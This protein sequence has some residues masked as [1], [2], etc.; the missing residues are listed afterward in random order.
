MKQIIYTMLAVGFLSIGC[1]QQE[2][3]SGKIEATVNQKANRMVDS[4]KTICDKN[5]DTQLQSRVEAAIKSNNQLIATPKPTIKPKSKPAAKPKTQVTATT[6]KAVNPKSTAVKGSRG[7]INKGGGVLKDKPVITKPKTQ[8][9]SPTTTKPANTN[10]QPTKPTGGRPG[11]KPK[12]GGG[13]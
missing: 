4:L 7:G 9:T 5:F 12:K 13:N 6:P 11:V 10:T 8:T 1:Q 2:D 3:I